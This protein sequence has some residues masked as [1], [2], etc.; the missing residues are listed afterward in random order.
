MVSVERVI[1]GIISYADNEILPHLPTNKACLL[2]AGIALVLRNPDKLMEKI[3][4]ALNV[5]EDN[6]VD[7]EALR[8]AFSANMRDKIEISIP[9]IG[10]LSFDAVEVDK[11]YD[12]IT[13]S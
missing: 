13:R 7:V 9:F 11:L 4:K 5:V 6:M 3:P 2:G 10:Q 1:R 12:Y 8:E